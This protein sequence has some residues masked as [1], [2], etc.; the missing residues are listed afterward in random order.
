MKKKRAKRYQVAT[1]LLFL[2]FS[3]SLM[4]DI[5]VDTDIDADVDVDIDVDADADI[6]ADVDIDVDTDVDTDVDISP[7]RWDIPPES[8]VFPWKD[9]REKQFCACQKNDDR[10]Y[11]YF[12]Y[13]G[14]PFY[15]M[16]KVENWGKDF[17]TDV[18]VKD[19]LLEMDYVVGSAEIAR[20]YNTEK[21]YHVG[22]QPIPEKSGETAA[23]KFPLGGDGYKIADRM[24]PC[25]T[26]TWTC[27]DGRLIRF[28]VKPKEIMIK[29]TI[30]YNMALISDGSGTIYKTNKSFPL[31]LRAAS[32][33]ALLDCLQPTKENCGGVDVGGCLIDDDC[34]SNEI[35]RDEKC[36]IQENL[37]RE[38]EVDF[39]AGDS[40]PSTEFSHIIPHDNDGKVLVVGQLKLNSSGC[41]RT[42]AFLFDEIF[43]SLTTTKESIAFSDVQLVYDK[44]DDG[45]YTDG[46][47]VVVSQEATKETAGFR[48]VI[49]KEHRRYLGRVDH[50]FLIIT[51]VDYSDEIVPENTTFTF[52]ISSAKSLHGMN[53][54]TTLQFNG[55][56]LY[57]ATFILEPSGSYLFAGRGENEPHPP[58]TS[59]G[60]DGDENGET[61]VMQFW[62]KSTIENEITKLVVG[63][64]PSSTTPFGKDL[65][66]FSLY[67]DSDGDGE[68]D[69]LLKRV[70]KFRNDQAHFDTFLTPVL[71][72]A[73]EKKIFLLYAD[74]HEITSSEDRAVFQINA[75]DVTLKTEVKTLGFPLL[76]HTFSCDSW[77]NCP[78]DGGCNGTGCMCSITTVDKGPKIY[79]FL[80]FL[81]IFL[82]GGLLL[83]RRQ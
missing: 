78:D 58:K 57:F 39:S 38:D 59:D 79:L 75:V 19:E 70:T 13:N 17:A 11:D 76:S 7:S 16:I 23:E 54:Y 63:L 44:D 41:L 71:Y 82:L 66:S 14:R 73:G 28:L 62:L 60:W 45:V 40:S 29:E 77:G 30:L 56:S 5:D 51:K 53:S 52:A 22:W 46:I 69:I 34:E 3:F 10:D 72:K 49:N 61:P 67:Q 55:R 18:W 27:S 36:V 25:D 43:V 50:N 1:F 21:N 42:R 15:Y 65:D 31:S 64:T 8:R 80:L 83:R 48:L 9:D 35:C 81:L 4:A 32:C 24:E 33:G 2:L 26:T 37:C 6:D 74:I 20:Y 12:C 68:G 47:D